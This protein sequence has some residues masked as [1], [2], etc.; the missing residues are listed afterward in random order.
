MTFKDFYAGK[1]GTDKRHMHPVVRDPSS[2]PKHPGRTVPHMHRVKHNNQK[3]QSLL[4]KPAGKY[5]LNRREV[6]QIEGEFHFKYDQD[7]PKKL[8][9]TGVTIKF[10]PV[11]QKPVLEK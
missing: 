7:K 5:A 3:V 11:L 6:A 10:D 8:G 1:I 4:K 2:H 9:N